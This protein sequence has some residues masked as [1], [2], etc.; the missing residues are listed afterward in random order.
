M[1]KFS[2]YFL[3]LLLA[4]L[5]MINQSNSLLSQE[6]SLEI[7]SILKSYN[8]YKYSNVY[9]F[10]IKQES[11]YR[12]N[13]NQSITEKVGYK[14]PLW[15]EFVPQLDN[16]SDKTKDNKEKSILNSTLKKDY[17]S[18]IT[19]V[20]NIGPIIKEYD[21]TIKESSIDEVL[22][23]AIDD[24]YG[25]TTEED[26]DDDDGQTNQPKD[27]NA[28]VQS[29]ENGELSPKEKFIKSVPSLYNYALNFVNNKS[30]QI[31][32]A[33]IITDRFSDLNSANIIGLVLIKNYGFMKSI[34]VQDFTNIPEKASKEQFLT[35]I[36][37]EIDKS[38]S[39]LSGYDISKIVTNFNDDEDF[40][41]SESA[42][43][44]DSTKN[45]SGPVKKVAK[46]NSRGLKLRD[47]LLNLID[48]QGAVNVSAKFQGIAD[49][50][51]DFLPKKYGVSKPVSEDS[52]QQY[53][54]ITDGQ[55]FEYRSKH[56]ITIGL[57]DL[58]RYRNYELPKKFQISDEDEED[59][60]EMKKKMINNHFL[61]VYGVELKY[62]LSE[63]NYPSLWS[64][65]M[66]LSAMW[67]SNKLGLI[68]PT[69][70]WSQLSKDFFNMERRLTNAGI[71]LYGSFD[72]PIK[73]INQG[74]V[75]NFNGSYV[76]GDAKSN[77]INSIIQ[78]PGRKFDGGD[79]SYST[80]LNLSYLPRFHAQAHYSFAINVDKYTFFRF[81][82]GATAFLMQRYAELAKIVGKD[83]QTGRDIIE[84]SN[85][86]IDQYT[87]SDLSVLNRFDNNQIIAMSSVQ[88]SELIAGL[89]G[90]IEFMTNTED[91]TVPWGGAMQYFDG[92]ISGDLWLQVPILG[93]DRLRDVSDDDADEDTTEV[94]S[95][96]LSLRAQAQFY[97]TV[98]RDPKPWE[99]ETVVLPS[100]QFLMN[101]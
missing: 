73:L 83:A 38:L 95:F 64:E 30:N 14:F 8:S 59:V 22:K 84:T 43:I 82:L 11:I 37:T 98:F 34:G 68:L 87:F 70:G 74:G 36:D 65:R 3:A 89:S 80:A 26:S 6:K 67:Q 94:S 77:P 69:N 44:E 97:Q 19:G 88:G 27:E 56:E 35:S 51:L 91:Q 2:N 60:I 57:F 4:L 12:L 25:R 53:L 58:I 32:D 5:T 50:E 61:P 24:V 66:T 92:S 28:E 62:G 1:F 45:D 75:F 101:F 48:Q 15:D 54:K 79:S 46:T 76:F 31:A 63:I 23:T 9:V 29:T 10:K 47:Y 90:R 20:N 55:P 86:K 85:R 33:Y 71:G 42:N 16:I 78:I 72:L 93:F 81:K 96:A 39:V 49:G 40:K 100:L 17:L 7:K 41:E 13:N 52:I 18:K 99:L 21:K